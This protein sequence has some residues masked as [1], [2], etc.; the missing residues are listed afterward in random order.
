MVAAQLCLIRK[1]GYGEIICK[2]G[3]QAFNCAADARRHRRSTRPS[4]VL[5]AYRA[6]HTHTIALQSAVG[7][8]ALSIAGMLL[9]TLGHLSLVSSAISQEIIDVLVVLNALR[10]AL[11]PK[12]IHDL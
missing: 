7:G 8:M 9:A 5:I 1:L 4:E 3:F 2:I 6:K 10:A 11:P 12:V